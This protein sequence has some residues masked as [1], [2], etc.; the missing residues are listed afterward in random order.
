MLWAE[1]IPLIDTVIISLLRLLALSCDSL[2]MLPGQPLATP[3][4]LIEV[5]ADFANYAPQQYWVVSTIYGH[6][7]S[8]GECVMVARL[9]LVARLLV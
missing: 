6:L 1:L 3:L 4:R 2:Y 7:L 8:R 9:L 5:F